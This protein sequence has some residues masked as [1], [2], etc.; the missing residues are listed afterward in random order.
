MD[1][2]SH[3][4]TLTKCAA[5]IQSKIETYVS[6]LRRLVQL[7]D[8]DIEAEE[9]RAGVFD[10]AETNYSDLALKLRLRRANLIAT[11]ALLESE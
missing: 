11:I 2:L 10:C 4:E 3:L 8:A 1:N 7:L 5:L 6:D 9:M